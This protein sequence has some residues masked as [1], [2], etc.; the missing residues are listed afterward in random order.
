MIKAI[1]QQKGKKDEKGKAEKKARE[2]TKVLRNKQ[3]KAGKDKKD[4]D[5][6]SNSN[7]NVIE[8]VPRDYTVVFEF[9]DPE[10]LSGPII[11]VND[12]SFY[13]D[14]SKIIFKDLNFGID[15]NSR[16][17]LVGYV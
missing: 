1:K 17:A 16:I 5:D 13:Y 10:M 14:P 2:D 3:R 8:K 11:Q 7:L 9:P 12:A 15:M 6:S 4:N